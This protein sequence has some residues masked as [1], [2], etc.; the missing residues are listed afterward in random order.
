MTM[1]EN[2]ENIELPST[3]ISAVSLT[4]TTASTVEELEIHR[5]F[6]TPK[7][8]KFVI[9]YLVDMNASASA[10]RAGYSED[11]S[12]VIG[13]NLLQKPHIQEAIDIQMKAR[14]ERT[15]ITSDYVLSGIKE[16]AERCLQ[17]KPV[18]IFDYE[19][20]KMVQKTELVEQKDGSYKEEGIWEFDSAGANKA[21]E[22][23]ARN[24]K[25]LTDKTE[26]GNLDGTNF[27]FPVIE[28]V[29]VA[30]P[31]AITTEVKSN[32]DSNSKP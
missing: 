13:F 30:S 27:E 28:E 32:G 26:V 11:T 23:L 10:R 22:N 29:F 6:L 16:I 1:D 7:Q 25:L 20:K 19:D 15:L 9:E 14:A 8:A 18:M 3:T 31:D 12:N 21:L 17:R 4:S 5:K 24:L 2:K